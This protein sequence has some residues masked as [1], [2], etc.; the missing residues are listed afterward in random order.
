MNVANVNDRK[1]SQLKMLA[2]WQLRNL[3]YDPIEVTLECLK[4]EPNA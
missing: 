1:L 2:D 4:R 3:G